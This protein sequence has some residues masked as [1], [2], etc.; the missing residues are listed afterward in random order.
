VD[1]FEI[2]ENVELIA[3]MLALLASMRVH[4][5][6]HVSL[7]KK[8]VPEPT[9]IIDWIVIQV[10]LVHILDQK[11][12]FLRNKDMGMVKVKW[13]CYGPKDATWEHKEKLWEEYPKSFVNFEENKI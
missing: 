3:Y 10:E 12:K 5:I 7:L 4:N 13:T 8:Y 11:V 2:L 6:F 9:H 1:L